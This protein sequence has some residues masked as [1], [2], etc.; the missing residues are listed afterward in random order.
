MQQ[1]QQKLK[2]MAKQSLMKGLRIS[3][4]VHLIAGILAFFV[5]GETQTKNALLPIAC[6]VM[7]WISYVSWLTVTG[8]IVRLTNLNN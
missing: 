8:E 3:S 6:F 5:M 2:Y 7:V 4:A 1:Q